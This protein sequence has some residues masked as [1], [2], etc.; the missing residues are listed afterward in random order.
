MG[1]VNQVLTLG[2]IILQLSSTCE[3]ISST[4]DIR[5]FAD[6]LRDTMNNVLF[7]WKFE[8]SY[9]EEVVSKTWNKTKIS[10]C[11]PLKLSTFEKMPNGL[12][13]G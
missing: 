8:N 7:R 2:F 10:K 13:L 1:L 6:L 11:N 5:I 9:F 4:C 12:T 3:Q